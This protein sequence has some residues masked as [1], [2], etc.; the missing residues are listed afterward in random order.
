MS[1]ICEI[2]GK[3]AM[4]GN[5]VSHAN[6]RTKRRFDI[7]LHKKRFYILEEDRWIT[8][9]VSAYGIKVIN[10]KGISLALKEAKENGFLK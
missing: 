2:T 8:L 7:N 3:K 9:K 6:N 1:R 10:K 5:N 4:V